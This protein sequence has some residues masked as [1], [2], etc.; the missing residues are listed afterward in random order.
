MDG[1]GRHRQFHRQRRG[2]PGRFADQPVQRNPRCAGRLHPPDLA[3]GLGRTPLR[4]RVGA[5]RPALRR[6]LP[7]LR[8]TQRALGPDPLFLQSADRADPALRERLH[9]RP[10][11]RQ[12]GDRQRQCAA[13]RPGGRRYLSR[14]AADRSATGRPGRLQPVAE[15]RGA[16]RT[17]GRRA[18]HPL[19]REEQ[20]PAGV[21]SRRRCRQPQAGGHR[22][23]RGG[24]R[25]AD[26]GRSGGR[27]APGPPEPG[28]RTA[29]R[30]PAGR[31][32]GGGRREHP[33]RRRA[34]PGQWRR[35][36][37]VRQRRGDRR[38]H[39]RPWRQP[40]GR[41]RVGADF[42]ERDD[43]WFR[44]FRPRRRHLARGRRRTAGCQRL[45]EQPAAGAGGQRYVG[46]P[47]R[48]TDFPAQRRRPEPGTGQSARRVVRGGA[49]GRRQTTGRTRRRHRLARQCRAGAGQRWPI[50]VGRHIEW[51]RHE[52]RRH[53]VAAERQGADRRRRPRGWQPATGRRFLPA[54]LRQLPGGRSLRIDGSRGCPGAGRAA[55]LP[56]R[57]RGR[58][59][60][61]WRGAARG[62]GGLDTAAVPGGCLGRTLDPTRR[63]GPVPAGRRRRQYPRAARSRQPDAGA[64]ARFAGRGRSGARHRPARSRTDHLG[65]HSERLGRT[66]RR[67]PAAVRRAR[68]YPGQSAQGPR[69]APCTLHLDWRAGIA[70]C[71]RP[72]CHCRGWARS[73]LWRSTVRRQHRHRRRDRSGQGDRDLGGCVRHRTPRCTTG[74]LRQPGT[75]GCTGTGKGF[76]DRRRRAHR[77]QF[78][79]WAVS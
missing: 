50:A 48:R 63:G 8:G 5:G 52:W 46:L 33:S 64:G 36:N 79:Q 61:G 58:R 69:P 38:R 13:R 3:E 74:G 44:R 28:Q 78:L 35:G 24:G 40:A 21:R 75:A 54:G 45:V 77:S 49:A 31:P 62:A 56:F 15:C 29:Q 23:R 16:R 73:P 51:S 70:G 6:H 32:E 72:R 76:A 4:T 60:R 27:R 47:R 34:D 12:S 53:A 65:W 30:L 59:G 26:P 20:R 39:H 68:R 18:L 37:P 1:P 14:R 71:C 11:R 19:L 41:Q 66:H 10:R 7:R 55:G 2:D 67:A 9:R 25:G 17:A 22:C 57:Q 43:R 42:P